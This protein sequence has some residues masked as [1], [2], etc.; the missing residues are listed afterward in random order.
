MFP[1]LPSHI[2]KPWLH[3]PDTWQLATDGPSSAWPALHE[4]YTVVFSMNS[5]LESVIPVVCT[6]LQWLGPLQFATKHLQVILLS[7]CDFLCLWHFPSVFMFGLRMYS[8]TTYHC[9]QRNIILK[10][11]LNYNHK[12]NGVCCKNNSSTVAISHHNL[13][14]SFNVDRFKVVHLFDTN[15][16]CGNN[17]VEI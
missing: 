13:F 5:P 2:G 15:S 17:I 14:R 16:L 9:P 3:I 7:G 12:Y 11:S 1:L 6:P 8:T 10:S 4:K